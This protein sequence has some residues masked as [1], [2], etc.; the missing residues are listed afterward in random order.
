MRVLHFTGMKS[1]KYGSLE[2]YFLEIIRQ[3]NERGARSFVQYEDTPSSKRYLDDLADREARLV[4]LSTD[5]RGLS[6]PYRAAR[7]VRQLRPTHIITHF[8]SNRVI[9]AIALTA[10]VSTRAR[11]VA[12]VHNLRYLTPQ[13]CSRL[14]YDR[15]DAVMAV[16][17]AVKEDLLRGR[18]ASQKVHRHYLG[19]MAD[20]DALDSDPDALDTRRDPL[21]QRYGFSPEDVVIANIAFDAPF[22]G[23]DVLLRAM[24]EVLRKHP[25]ARLLQIGVDPVESHLRA[26]AQSLGIGS[27]I[28][29]A[30]IVDGG[31][32]YLTAADIYVQPSRSAEGLPLAIMEAMRV[33]LPVV[34]TGVSGNMEAVAA[35]RTGLIVT[36]DSPS[37]L[38]GGLVRLIES[39]QVWGFLGANGRSRYELLFDGPASVRTLLEHYVFV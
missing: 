21:R 19:L 16:S 33:G 26:F 15:C 7:L 22:K 25:E 29:F 10:K 30:G 11:T 35:E 34:A 1:T 37:E 38:A 23:V 39:P 13:S 12:F 28:V 18:V 9:L 3:C 4:I 32:R 14:A 6:G 20:A 5:T 17:E 36:P 8:A 27:K 24:S 2:S 31:W